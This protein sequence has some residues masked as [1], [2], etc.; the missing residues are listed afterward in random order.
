MSSFTGNASRSA[1][2]TSSRA[3]L[4]HASGPL[5]RGQTRISSSFGSIGLPARVAEA[6][7]QECV[8]G[9]GEDRVHAQEPHARV[10]ECAAFYGILLR[11]EDHLGLAQL[12]VARLEQVMVGK[13]MPL[14]ADAQARQVLEETRGMADAG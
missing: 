14:S 7:E 12:E 13:R 8:E 4:R 2:H 10:G 5:H 3:S 6:L 11:H 1:L 9:L